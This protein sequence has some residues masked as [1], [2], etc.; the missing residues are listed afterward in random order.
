MSQS[1]QRAAHRFGL[2]AETVAALWLRMKG[3]RVLARRFQANGAEIDLVIRRG[4]MIA[5]VEVKAR[6]GADEALEAVTAR[7]AKQVSRAA[8]AWLS[9]HPPKPGTSVRF[10]AVAIAPGR[11]PRHVEAVHPLNIDF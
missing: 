3:Y 10:D 9:R 11:L 2:G 8:R 5:F 7:K 6:P 4:T 1:R